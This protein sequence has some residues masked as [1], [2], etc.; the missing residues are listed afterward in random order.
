MRP[1]TPAVSVTI[2]AVGAV[3]FSTQFS[4]VVSESHAALKLELAAWP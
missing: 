3:P 1:A 4:S 2:C